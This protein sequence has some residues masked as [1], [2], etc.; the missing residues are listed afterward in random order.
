MTCAA[1]SARVEKVSG[2]VPGVRSANVNL[3]KGTLTLEADSE[4]V[5]SAVIDAV[6]KAGYQIH[7]EEKTPK[8]EQNNALRAMKSRIIF[9]AVF[10]VVLMYITMGHMLH[11]PGTGWLHAKENSLVFV[12]LQL[13]F[14]LPVIYCNRAYYS[15]GFKALLHR[16]ANM[17]SLI[18]VG[19]GAAL[20]Y[21]IGAFY[22]MAWALGNGQWDV[23]LQ[24]KDNLYFESA[25]MILTLITL[26]KFLEARAKGKTGDAVKQLMNLAPKTASVLRNG[27]E[28][29]VPVESLVVGDI[30]VVRS[31]GSIPVDGVILRGRASVDQSAL[32][33]ESVPIEKTV[34]DNVSAGT[35][36]TEG[37]L[38]IRTD[39]CGSDTTLAQVIRLVEEA[40]GSKAPIA[41][42]A[43]K[44]AGIFVPCVMGIALVTFV[45]W[46]IAKA[47]F[48]FAVNSA[49]S[50]LVISCPC[51]LGLA[52]PV[53]IMVATGK[54]ATM[55][56]L[57]KNAE[58]LE[59]LHKVDTVVLDKT[60]TLTYGKPAVTD[61]I[62]VSAGREDLLQ[63]AASL[64]AMSEHPFA[65]AILAYT[66]G[67]E[68]YVAS[69]YATIPG[70]GVTAVINGKRYY[71]GNANM[72]QQNHISVPEYAHLRD[73]GKTPL[74]FACEDGTFL[75]V[76]AAADILRED[77]AQAIQSLK[78]LKLRVVMLTGDNRKTASAIAQNAG[79]TEVISD[80]LPTEKAAAVVKLKG[81]G[82][83]VLMVGDGIND[84]PALAVADIGMAIGSG[85][86]IAV[87][88]A[89]VVLMGAN[90]LGISHAIMLSKAAVRNIRQNLFWAFFYNILGIPLAAGVLYP[91]FGLLLTPM[92]G[93]AAM[94]LSSVFVVT[95]AL[96]LHR[97]KPKEN[98]LPT[99]KKEIEIKEEKTMTTVLYVEGMM[100]PHCQARVEKACKD[101]PG[102]TEAVVD[103]KAKN[104]TVTGEAERDILVK[105][106]TDAGYE[107]IG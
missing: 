90:L 50:V 64:E 9:S 75:G 103:L 102:V 56:V 62:P 25:A 104:V 52:T 107:V 81:D 88:S 68:T 6:V 36:N 67:V 49:I 87:E 51:A 105:A 77:A 78:A 93:A 40:G 43:D 32:T 80:V 66:A 98:L 8:D 82:A 97:F 27:E 23:V 106:I 46:M 58:V 63:I 76:I 60:G 37:Y 95:N 94:S 57:F 31:G 45:V 34:H 21:G 30:V 65:K 29:V 2:A 24:Y 19:S 3:L 12:L 15:R 53:A 73:A 83:N 13:T 38:E 74:Y 16:S 91:V 14:T 79:I 17:D 35:I 48:E 59:N 41:R 89:G 55:G 5:V 28:T 101:V 4:N 85:T 20:L 26:G 84:S 39:K 7:N 42:L 18:A 100:C 92:F 61:V 11:L 72:M 69:D 70:Q 99:Y 1:C 44:I 10:L 33:G 96:R 54:A 22:R 86:D 71:G 47:D